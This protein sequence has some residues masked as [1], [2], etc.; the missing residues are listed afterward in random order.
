MHS[1]PPGQTT[2]AAHAALGVLALFVVVVLVVC[3]IVNR[4]RVRLFVHPVRLQYFFSFLYFVCIYLRHF[5]QRYLYTCST[6]TLLNQFLLRSGFLGSRLLL[7]G[8]FL[9]FFLFFFFQPCPPSGIALPV[10]VAKLRQLSL[11]PQLQGAR[12]VFEP[13]LPG[14]AVGGFGL[15]TH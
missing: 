7:D 8:G 4:I 15:I 13:P 12:A 5:R 10:L 11:L 3:G 2:Y 14:G 1:V 9:R 6:C